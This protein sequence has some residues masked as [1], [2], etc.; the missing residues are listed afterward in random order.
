MIQSLYTNVQTSVV[1]VELSSDAGKKFMDVTCTSSQVD[2]RHEFM[3][4]I[5]GTSHSE[6]VIY[7][8]FQTWKIK[9]RVGVGGGRKRGE[10]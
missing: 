4:Q 8:N 5:T 10:K 2:C 3:S 1:L 6:F 9:E 7:F